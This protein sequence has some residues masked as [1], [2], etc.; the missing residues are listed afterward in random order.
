L[1]T[2]G[3]A[4]IEDPCGLDHAFLARNLKEGLEMAK[5]HPAFDH[6]NA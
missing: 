1:V 3:L 2:A 4:D 6:G 5:P